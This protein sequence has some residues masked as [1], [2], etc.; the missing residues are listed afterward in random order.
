MASDPAHGAAAPA[1]SRPSA[2]RAVSPLGTSA[3]VVAVAHV[4]VARSLVPGLGVFTGALGAALL[5]LAAVVSLGRLV[6]RRPRLP[7]V[8]SWALL[9]AAAVL[10]SAV[11]LHYVRAV[12]PSGDEVDYLMMAQSVWREGD[13]DLRD[14]FARGD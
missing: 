12:E 10:A 11:A 2:A 9:A 8:P 3:L 13:I 4:E 7:P 6:H 1:R 14:N 5:V